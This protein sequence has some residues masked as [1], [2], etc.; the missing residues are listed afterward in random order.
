MY[1]T[2][3]NPKNNKKI[4]I[5]SNLGKKI[6]KKYLIKKYGGSLNYNTLL[7]KNEPENPTIEL[8]T[9]IL[10]EQVE[11]NDYIYYIADHKI[12][13]IT[14]DSGIKNQK[15]ETVSK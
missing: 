11:I 6:L 5:I 9:E 1:K 15:M 2:I 10:K 14:L 3:I 13:Y 4:E 8:S 12:Y 7:L